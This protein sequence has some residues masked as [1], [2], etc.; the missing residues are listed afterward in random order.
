MI[1]ELILKNG[2]TIKWKYIDNPFTEKHKAALKEAVLSCKNLDTNKWK[3][4]WYAL[5][6]PMS[7][8]WDSSSI[9]SLIEELK[10]C[11]V[12]INDI[13]D[14]KKNK[15]VEYPIDIDDIYLIKEEPLKNQMLL[16]QIHRY[17]TIFV[18]SRLKH[19]TGASVYS[20][21]YVEEDGY[22]LM[23][24]MVAK[25]DST[26]L[27]QIEP[28]IYKEFVYIGKET[29]NKIKNLL[30][31][32]NQIVHEIEKYIITPNKVKMLEQNFYKEYCVEFLPK[33]P[34]AISVSDRKFNSYNSEADV[35]YVINQILGKSY[36]IAYVDHDDPSKQ[37]I[38]EGTQYTGSF[39][40]GDRNYN[41][42]PP[43]KNW[44]KK[45]GVS[46][47]PY[48]FPLGKIIEGKENLNGIRSKDIIDIE[49]FE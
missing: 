24:E 4:T 13:D 35:W 18:Q 29:E 31:R 32:T 21:Y 2:K 38:W 49:I 46:S 44:M 48:G 14:V 33:L 41:K 40:L 6:Q 20:W 26:V 7:T 25:P 39:S 8:S 42:W 36:P 30:E 47:I 16:N 1:V 23:N 28:K 10:K 22:N 5:P 45:N 12:E 17:F 34:Y 3:D 43:F 19:I 11:V 37:D 15:K 27:T 9:N